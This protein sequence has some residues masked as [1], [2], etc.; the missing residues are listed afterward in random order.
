MQPRLANGLGFA[1]KQ[2]FG[3]V[4]SRPRPR[5]SGLLQRDPL[6]RRSGLGKS[7]AV[8]CAVSVTLAGCLAAADDSS[9]GRSGGT[10]A[11]AYDGGYPGRWV[12][13]DGGSR[14]GFSDAGVWR[15]PPIERACDRVVSCSVAQCE[16]WGW[17]A[18]G[19]RHVDC[20]AAL[21]GATGTHAAVVQAA[22]CAAV[23]QIVYTLIPALVWGCEAPSCASACDRSVD[24][25][26]T[27]CQGFHVAVREQLVADC[28]VG[29]NLN[30]AQWRYE[31][32][33]RAQLAD[34]ARHDA[35]FER[36]CRG[37]GP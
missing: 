36:R 1:A 20:L 31:T 32:S 4:A 16:T 21:G 9:Q 12:T 34:R 3:A 7:V 25:L 35:A 26:V 33:C 19:G 15:L 27:G 8:L 11:G 30:D 6:D 18:A 23:K 24:C 14:Y 28:M 17:R 29:C 22:D 13:A 2:V 5:M 10:S 37:T